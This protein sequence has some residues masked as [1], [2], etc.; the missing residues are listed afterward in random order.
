MEDI[1]KL[2][3]GFWQIEKKDAK[4]VFIEGYEV[5]YR[6]F[7]TAIAYENEAE[8]GEAIKELKP[9]REDIWITS[10]IPAEIKS[11]KKAKKA[12]DESLARLGVDYLDLMLIHAP[13]PWVFMFMPGPRYH[14]G[15]REVWRAMVEAKKEGKIKNLGVSNFNVDD[16]KNITDYSSEPIYANQILIHIGRVP[17][18]VIKYCQSHNILVEA[19]SPLGVG[20][21]LKNE[22]IIEMAKKNNVSPAQLCIKYVD[23]LDTIPLPRSRSKK[24]MENNFHFD[25]ELSKEDKETLDKLKI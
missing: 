16:I 20:K 23:E 11:Y 2:G 24:H 21:L 19:Y 18:K 12:I 17:E 7:D 3:L 4:R 9:N 6:H 1:P 13:K 8:I 25:F 14:K 10:K 15:N 22:K 5:G